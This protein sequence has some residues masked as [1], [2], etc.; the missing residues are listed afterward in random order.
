MIKILLCSFLAISFLSAI[1]IDEL[2]KS[3]FE[4][5]YDLK[6]IENSVKVA[7][8]QINVS[9][10]WENPM[11]AFK[12]NNIGLDKPLS[13]QKEYG[14]ELSQAIPF[15]DKLNIEESIAIKDKNIKTF[16]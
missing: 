2:V 12:T 4:K 1:T 15:G 10:N 11:L 5:N 14:I 6:S 16:D 8:E 7:Q 9:K 3:S 13:N